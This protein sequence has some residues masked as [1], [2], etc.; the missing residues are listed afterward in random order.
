MRMQE[1]KLKRIVVGS[2][3]AGVLLILCLVVFLIIQFVMMGQ[4]SAQL[5]W[6]LQEKAR[7]DD[8]IA[9]K[10]GDLDYYSSYQGR[11]RLAYQYGYTF[12]E[13]ANN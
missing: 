8:E 13:D 11:L 10:N 1:E 6:E 12:P 7:L 2:T 3:V 5:Q 9:Q 4:K